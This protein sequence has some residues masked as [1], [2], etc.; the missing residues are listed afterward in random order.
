MELYRKSYGKE[1]CLTGKEK[2]YCSV[3]AITVTVLLGLFFYRSWIAAVLMIPVGIL[4]LVMLAEKKIKEKR[5]H[6][7]N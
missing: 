4:Y 7:R 5:N 2:I 3:Q 6:L 1:S